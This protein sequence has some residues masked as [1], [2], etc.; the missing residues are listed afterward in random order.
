MR[1]RLPRTF[2]AI[3][4][5]LV[6]WGGS[7]AAGRAPLTLVS[8]SATTPKPQRF[9]PFLCRDAVVRESSET[10]VLVGKNRRPVIVPGRATGGP[11]EKFENKQIAKA[12]RALQTYVEK[13]TGAK[14][15]IV[16]DAAEG[17]G[18]RIVVHTNGSPV[19]MFPKL[20]GADAHGFIIATRGRDLH[21]VGGSAV[22]TLYGVWFFLQ[23]YCGLRIVMP[24][25]LGEVYEQRDRLEIP[26]ELY[27]LNS[28][29]DFLL[30]IHSLNIR[31]NPS[32][33]LPRSEAA[34]GRG[35]DA[36]RSGHSS[37]LDAHAR[38]DRGYHPVVW[39][40]VREV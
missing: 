36:A 18:V 26:Q 23:N 38:R 8:L 20:E 1:A 39:R 10:A 2:T 35:L 32:L 12:A 33:A 9:M 4:A 5:A 15:P 14:P 25:E 17:T 7:W 22:G 21:I 13:I 29:P 28:G 31:A 19:A 6:P 11:R 3:V 34:R 37:Q 16:D 40:Q 24:G 30:R 27:V